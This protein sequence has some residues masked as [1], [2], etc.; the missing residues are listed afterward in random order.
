MTTRAIA[1]TIRHAKVAGTT[2]E[3]GVT[4]QWLSQLGKKVVNWVLKGYDEVK[5]ALFKFQHP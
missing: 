4:K 1:Q 2:T 3:I 5:D